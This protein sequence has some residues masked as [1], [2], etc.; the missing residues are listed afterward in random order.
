[1]VISLYA[2]VL[3]KV[4]NDTGITVLSGEGTERIFSNK[5]ETH[6][7]SNWSTEGQ[8]LDYLKFLILNYFENWKVLVYVVMS[9]NHNEI[10]F[11]YKRSA[12]CH[13]RVGG[14]TLAPCGQGVDLIHLCF[15]ST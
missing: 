1:M 7:C 10:F 3:I 11:I 2:I 5:T 6:T 13:R 4:L 12:P 15:S 14:W 9:S 8:S